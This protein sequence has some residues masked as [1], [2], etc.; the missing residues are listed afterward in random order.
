MRYKCA[1]MAAVLACGLVAS[2]QETTGGKYVSKDGGYTVKFPAGLEVKT[3]NQD[4]P[5]GLKMV[6]T[7]GESEKKA[8]MVMYMV[9]PE[10]MLKAVPA[11]A[12]LDGAANGA[13]SKSGGKEVST[14]DLTVG[15]EM[16]PGREVVVDKDGN[17]VRTQI[18][19][20]DKVYV[21]VVGGPEEFAKGKAANDFLKSFEITPPAGKKTVSDKN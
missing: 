17:L 14:K 13:V 5:G 7:G 20:A 15:K 21:L 16:F 9:M 11:K 10:G 3:K 18:I 4:A 2:G 6:M 8:Y 1:A 12:I 19:I